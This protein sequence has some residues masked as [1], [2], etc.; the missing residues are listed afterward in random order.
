MGVAFLEGVTIDGISACVPKTEIDNLT[1]GRELYGDDIES[2][3]RTTGVSKRRVSKEGEI[4]ALD[5]SVYAA[6]KLF[7]YG[8]YSRGDFSG[9]IF[10]TQTPDNLMPN[11]ATYCQE[12]LG[13]SEEIA[14]FDINIACSG[15]PF[16]LFAAGSLA[17]STGKP[18][19]LLDG[20]TNS[21]YVSP[22][23]KVTALLF[24]DAGTASVVSPNA[25]GGIWT[26]DFETIGSKRSALIIPDG[27]YRN[28]INKYSSQYKQCEDGGFRRPI[29]MYMNG[30][31]VYNFV[32]KNVPKRIK[33]LIERAN[34]S[35]AS[36]DWLVLH[37]ANEYM[38][39]QVARS[40]KIPWER[41][42]ISI[43]KYGNSSSPTVPITL[44][45]ELKDELENANIKSIIMAGFGAGL[46]IGAV[47]MK[48][49]SVKCAG[50]FDYE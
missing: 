12:L 27:G 37:Q 29:D 16:G 35:S 7:E 33:A 24:G 19:L 41:V 46:S 36:I 48:L 8:N 22:K 20:E 10:V 32:A 14:A 30:M 18:V 6:H 17:K 26:F 43:G 21:H 50:V 44:C 1:F 42:P 11:N 25:S 4:T 45:S 23:D 15:Y 28:R 40:V 39:K 49:G 13:L 38:L 47:H 9:V 3:I 5:L 34:E 2:L 31:D